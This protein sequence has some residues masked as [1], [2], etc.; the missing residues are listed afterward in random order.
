VP[1]PLEAVIYP[2]GWHL[3]FFESVQRIQRK[4]ESYGHS[5]FIPQFA[6][7]GGSEGESHAGAAVDENEDVTMQQ[8]IAERV[9]S[10]RQ[11][12]HRLAGSED[13]CRR[14]YHSYH[15]DSYEA[16][17]RDIRNGVHV[18]DD[19]RAAECVGK[20]SVDVHECIKV[21]GSNST[22]E[23]GGSADDMTS[24]NMTSDNMTSDDMTSDDMTSGLQSGHEFPYAYEWIE[25][26]DALTKRLRSMWEA[27]ASEEDFI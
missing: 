21:G 20:E 25:Y 8:K 1:L 13:G 10:G 24:D 12:D 22:R 19:R 9:K 18:N 6:G 2:G 16:R 3:S 15:K 17:E 27:I 23:D 7:E 14:R 4:L 5:N 11:I 26:E